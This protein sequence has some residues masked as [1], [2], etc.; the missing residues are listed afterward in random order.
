MYGLNAAGQ[1][2]FNGGVACSVLSAVAVLIRIF[3]K[4]RY[5]Q[6]VHS[7]DYWIIV[8]LAFYW[9]SVAFVLWGTSC[10]LRDARL[11]AN[12]RRKHYRRWR[13]GDETASN[14]S[15]ERPK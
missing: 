14:A 13:Y 8:G 6:G 11:S 10:L 15:N 1:S 7:D 5:K 4:I 2:Q 9:T 3:C 12:L